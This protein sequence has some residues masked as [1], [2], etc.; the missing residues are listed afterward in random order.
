[1]T[2]QIESGAGSGTMLKVI[3]KPQ[4]SNRDRR[5]ART[6]GAKGLRRS[7]S[8]AFWLLAACLLTAYLDRL[9]DPPAINAHSGVLIA[10]NAECHSYTPADQQVRCQWSN[11]TSS[12]FIQWIQGGHIFE[13]EYRLH[14]LIRNSQASDSSPPSNSPFIA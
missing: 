12:V 13:I 10:L 3:A 4:D 6:N 2:R 14:R 8:L 7:A 9:P 1:M 5:S 11:S